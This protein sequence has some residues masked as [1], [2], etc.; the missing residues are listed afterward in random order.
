MLLSRLNPET[1]SYGTCGMARLSRAEVIDPN[2]VTIVHVINRTVRRCFLLGNDDASGRNF[3][4]RRIW[5]EELLQQ[6]AACFGIDLLTFSLLSNH[7]HLILRTRPDLVAKWNDT[8]VARRWLTICPS[9]RGKNKKSKPTE[10]ELSSFCN[11]P[12][13][14][15]E[16]RER[17]SSVSWWM[18][19]LNQRV[20]QRANR[21]DG[22]HGRFWQDRFRAIRLIDEE[23]LLACAVYVELNPIRAAMAEKIEDSDF[24]SIQR[25]IEA[26]KQ[27][28]EES[29]DSGPTLADDSADASADGASTRPTPT[30]T[31]GERRDA[32]LAK[33]TL[34]E[35]DVGVGSGVSA[36]GKRCS[37]KG[38]LQMDLPTY[39]ELLDWTARQIVPGK[40]GCTPQETPPVLKRLGLQPTSW[41][42]LVM[43]FEKSFIHL[44]GRCDRIASQRSHCS[45]RRFCIPARTRALIPAPN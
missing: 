12:Q 37:D 31:P 23:S 30:L 7:Y 24:T 26:E 43:D 34:E 15:A 2:D 16:A 10:A 11:C 21:E 38:F 3:D 36:T 18:R 8:E 41:R 40:A 14:I 6:F 5:I 13:K 42:E 28:A 17:L 32:F 35:S 25:R 1:S 20:A 4:H 44:A 19:L 27:S 33:L 9:G 45:G 22:E 29:P 39:L